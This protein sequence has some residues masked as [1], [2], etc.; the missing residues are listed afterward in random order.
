MIRNSKQGCPR[1]QITNHKS[2]FYFWLIVGSLIVCLS[3]C[4]P[5]E[6]VVL[7]QVREIIVDGDTDP[8]LRAKAVLYN[9]N[10][11]RMKLRKVN[12]DVLV[13]GK[14]A[15]IISQEMKVDVPANGEFIV[16]LEAKLDLKE[17]GLLDTLLGMLGGRKMNVHYKGSIS[18]TYKT[19]PIKV[20]VNYKGEVKLRF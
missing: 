6:D 20:P 18:I 9:P 3:G 17:L 11:M 5:K 16:P 14:K 8:V 1:G 4:G 7:K 15:A 10:N 2:Q 13:N 19:M 12:I